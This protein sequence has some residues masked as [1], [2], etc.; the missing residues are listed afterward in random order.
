MIPELTAR[1]PPGG[2][3]LGVGPEQNFSY[4]AAV[5]PRLAFVVDIRRGNLDLQLLYKA[6]FELAKDRADFVALLFAKPRPSDLSAESTVDQIFDAF[7]QSPAS[8]ALFKTHL[9]TIQAHLT[10]TRQLPLPERDRAGVEAVYDRL[11]I[12]SDYPAAWRAYR[13]LM[14]GKDPAGV[15]RSFL[16]TEARFATVK[17]LHARNLIV[18]IVGDFS[19]PKA[20]RAIGQ[21]LRSRNAVATTFY[22]SNVEEYL[23]PMLLPGYVSQDL[24]P[25]FCR[26]VAALPLDATSTFVR[27]TSQRQRGFINSLGSMLEETSQCPSA[28][29]RGR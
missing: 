27:A 6:M 29:A 1:V 7:E 28:R 19:G 21:F 4:I 11:F 25:D 17:T 26:N 22:V 8:R 13:T 20:I 23:K 12:T 2:V 15:A 10:K 5:Q 9:D 3:Y 16:A 14:T 24:W 18:P